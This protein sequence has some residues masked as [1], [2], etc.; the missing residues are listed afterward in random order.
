[1]P[2]IVAIL[3]LAKYRESQKAAKIHAR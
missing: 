3:G 1:L 2:A